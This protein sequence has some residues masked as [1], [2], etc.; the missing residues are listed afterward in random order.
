MY[1]IFVEFNFTIKTENPMSAIPTTFPKYLMEIPT[2]EVK[3]AWQQHY[4]REYQGEYQKIDDR[5]DGLK[6]PLCVIAAVAALIFLS[7]ILATIIPATTAI[8]VCTIV[9]LNILGLGA[10]ICGAV[11]YGFKADSNGKELDALPSTFPIT[12]QVKHFQVLQQAKAYHGA[13]T[14]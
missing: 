4:I 10:G 14:F 6:A 2:P 9:A 12:Y 3:N 5:M 1:M 13:K 8:L 7:P 11:Y